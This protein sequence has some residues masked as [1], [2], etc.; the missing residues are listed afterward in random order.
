MR[1][2]GAAIIAATVAVFGVA[3]CGGSGQTNAQ[4]GSGAVTGGIPPFVSNT[5]LAVVSLYAK[6]PHQSPAEHKK[7]PETLRP[8]GPLIRRMRLTPAVNQFTVDLAPGVYNGEIR[9]PKGSFGGGCPWG[10]APTRFRVRS[11]Q[12]THLQLVRCGH[13]Y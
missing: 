8:V 5:G 3:G 11:G 1:T 10:P 12:T 4:T 2:A 13:T 7:H 6:G 9:V